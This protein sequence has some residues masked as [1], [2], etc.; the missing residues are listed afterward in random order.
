[1]ALNR[2]ALV[3]SVAAGEMDA[4][5]AAEWSFHGFALVEAAGRGAAQVLVETFPRL[6]GEFPAPTVVLA[7]P[8]NNAADALVILRSLILG[9]LLAAER[10]LI[11]TTRAVEPGERSP[12]SEAYA[13]LQKMGVRSLVFSDSALETETRGYPEG[14]LAKARLIMDGIAGTGL[15]G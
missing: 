9:G 8:G 10:S 15:R 4:E 3:G 14:P 7:G 11:I 6:F 2:E 13:S 5:A 12:R 1:M